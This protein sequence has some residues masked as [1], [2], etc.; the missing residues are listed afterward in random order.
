MPSKLANELKKRRG[1]ATPQQEVVVS[2]L[3]TNDDFQY[4][5]GRLFREHG[6]TQAQY[7]VL[8]ILRG[9][10]GPLPVLEIRERMIAR[11]AAVTG[12][13]DKLLARKLVSRR[14]CDQDRR[15]W[16]VELAPAGKKLLEKMQESVMGMHSRLCSGLTVKECRTLSALLQKAGP[17]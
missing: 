13:V 1:F 3:R 5:F 14:Q 11:T 6:L 15:T 4:Q 2:V 9:E 12:L 10:G 16:Y 7:N 8:T 17:T